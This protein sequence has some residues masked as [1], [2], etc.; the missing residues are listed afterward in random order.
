MIP[1]PPGAAAQAALRQELADTAEAF[2]GIADTL[3]QVNLPD[4]RHRAQSVLATG[5]TVL[6]AHAESPGPEI[7]SLLDGL[8]RGL[9]ALNV[10]TRDPDLGITR[11]LV[12][13][14]QAVGLALARLAQAQQAAAALGWIAP[15][16]ALPAPLG[17]AVARDEAPLG[18][19]RIALGLEQIARRLDHIEIGRAHV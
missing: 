9:I 6:R 10:P 14:Q 5:R 7:A 15:E 16:P 11:T 8:I 13:M 3:P 1:L 17:A 19:A 12:Q 18:L 4:L 2:D